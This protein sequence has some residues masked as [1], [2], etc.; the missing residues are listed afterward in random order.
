[1]IETVNFWDKPDL[2]IIAGSKMYG[3]DTPSSDTDIRGFVIEPADNYLGRNSFEQY[4]DEKSDTVIWGFRRFLELVEKG[5]PNA[6]EILYAPK[7]EVLTDRGEYVLNSRS[8]FATKNITDA[9]KGFAESEWLKTQVLTKN[10]ETGEIYHSPRVVGAQRKNSY[11]EFGYCVKN[12]CHTIRLLEEGIELLKTGCI[13]FP[14]Q[15]AQ[16][17]RSIRNGEIE[18]GKL[19][20][21]HED[22]VK[23]FENAES[24]SSLPEK[25]DKEKISNLYYKMIKSNVI[26]FFEQR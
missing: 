13:T 18:F 7:F 4:E 16:F 8:L 14:R 2:L 15:N 23:K 26:S 25:P 22:L 20:E 1:M 24:K 10:K 3:Y 19:S 12:A 5:S 17:L 21:I 6:F 9:I 11:K